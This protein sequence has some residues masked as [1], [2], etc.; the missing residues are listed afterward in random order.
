M[1]FAVGIVTVVVLLGGIAGSPLISGPAAP[2]VANEHFWAVTG[3]GGFVLGLS[4]RFIFWDLPA[5]IGTFF[6]AHRRNFRYLTV[7][8]AGIAV[9]V[10]I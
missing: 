8:A 9:L 5:M 7:L 4:W 6:R 2:A 1:M 3:V 10:M